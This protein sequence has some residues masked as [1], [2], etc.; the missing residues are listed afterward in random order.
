[1][2]NLL[3]SWP[4]YLAFSLLV[5]LIIATVIII[6]RGHFKAKVGDKIIDV[7]DDHPAGTPSSDGHS[8]PKP[9]STGVVTVKR[10][11]GDCVLI[12]M[13]EREKY[14]LKMRHE[15]DRI[16]K[17]QMGFSEQKL[18]EIQS[19]LINAYADALYLRKEENKS[20]TT[21]IETVQH[22]L[23]YGLI[24][25]AILV[26]KDEIR[27]AFKENGFFDLSGIDLTYFVKAKAKMLLSLLQQHFRNLY[28]DRGVI[29]NGYDVQ[30]I[31]EERSV[32]LESI[33]AEMFTYSKDARSESEDK[34][35]E[36]KTQFS[37]WID[38]MI[39]NSSTK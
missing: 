35:K 4:A 12:M 7:G 24:R 13:G 1:M 10:T 36:I 2:W 20:I 34:I 39:V 21:E 29:L 23:F 30:E 8:V 38:Q 26:I 18:I 22:K 32:Q 6:L 11:C 37:K 27:R 5:L 15:T 17:T 3:Q 19:L 31:I 33:L 9:P 14:E 16:L 25:D 28:P